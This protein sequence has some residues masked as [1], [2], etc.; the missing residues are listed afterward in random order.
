MLCL[1]PV[2]GNRG[3]THVDR[4]PLLFFCPLYWIFLLTR[5]GRRLLLIMILLKCLFYENVS[6][7][8]PEIQYCNNS[9]NTLEKCRTF[10][11]GNCI[12]GRANPRRYPTDTYFFYYYRYFFNTNPTRR[13]HTKD[14]DT[15]RSPPNSVSFSML[16]CQYTIQ[17]IL[18][19]DFVW[20][21]LDDDNIHPNRRH[22]GGTISLFLFNKRFIFFFCRGLTYF[23]IFSKTI[24]TM[25]IVVLCTNISLYD[26]RLP[27]RRS[28]L[29]SR[30]TVFEY[31]TLLTVINLI[32]QW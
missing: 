12:P 19:G 20:Y 5:R 21:P 24:T 27:P 29:C 22:C 26:N 14:I 7:R 30:C 9:F 25:E 16:F 31:M 32:G 13:R 15:I 4:G 17:F 3:R 18:Y 2:L 8:P 6:R 1:Y 23:R 11:A 28:I 10:S